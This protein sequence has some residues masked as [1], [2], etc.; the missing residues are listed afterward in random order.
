MITVV[1]NIIV[2]TLQV[3]NIG[4][5]LCFVI[6]LI[7]AGRWNN[8]EDPYNALVCACVCACVSVCGCVRVCVCMCARMNVRLACVCLRVNVHMRACTCGYVCAY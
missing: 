8:N 2:V 3:V 6:H 1:Y 5:S 7:I 4:F